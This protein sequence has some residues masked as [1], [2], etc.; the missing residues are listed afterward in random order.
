MATA[1]TKKTKKIVPPDFMIDEG[2]PKKLDPNLECAW[3]GKE[4]LPGT[5]T[6]KTPGLALHEACFL[7]WHE[8][9]K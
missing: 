9:P 3:C 8:N 6:D 1:K 7:P 5:G 2:T 4:V